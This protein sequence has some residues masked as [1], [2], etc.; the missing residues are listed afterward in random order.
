MSGPSVSPTRSVG[1]QATTRTAPHPEP[2]VRPVLDV[3]RE[4]DRGE[5][6]A[7]A[8]P[9]G[10]EGEQAE[11]R[12][13][14]RQQLTADSCQGAAN[15]AP[16][17]ADYETLERTCPREAAK[18]AFSS[19]VPTVTADRLRRAEARERPDDDALPQQPVEERGAV[20]DLGEEEVPHAGPAG[21]SPCPRRAASISPRPAAF[22]ARRRASSSAPSRL[23]SAAACAGAVTSNARRTLL[24]AATTSGGRDGVA[25]AEAREPVDLRERPQH[26]DAP[27]LRGTAGDAVEVVG[28][29]DVLEVR[30]VE[31]GEHVLREPVDEREQLC[32]GRSQCRSGCS[33]GRRRRAS[34]A[35]RSPRA[36]PSRS[37]TWSRSGTFRATAPTF[38]ASRT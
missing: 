28:V 37:Y 27:A 17:R 16:F 13:A 10:G 25:D 36:A 32:Y 35:A 24:V 30:L 6:R 11:A 22:S 38:A 18:N 4:G 9:E 19:G 33:D 2:G 7:D 20:A 12:V 21:S 29:V 15:L 8:R 14:E 26:R 23:A 34:C 5:E 1:I 31:D 3:H